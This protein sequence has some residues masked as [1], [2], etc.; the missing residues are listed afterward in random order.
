MALYNKKPLVI[1]KGKKI[2]MNIRLVYGITT[3]GLF[4]YQ[5]Y[6]P[7]CQEIIGFSRYIYILNYTNLIYTWYTNMVGSWYTKL[8]SLY[9][10]IKRV[11]FSA[12]F[13][14]LFHPTLPTASQVS[15]SNLLLHRILP[16]KLDF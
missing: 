16:M 4:N 7:N 6:F 9:F 15:Y 14:Q 8:F 10:H 13:F 12:V 2:I 1:G 3:Y 11:I 5:S